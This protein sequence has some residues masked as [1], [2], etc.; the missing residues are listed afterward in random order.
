MKSATGWL[1]INKTA[2]LPICRFEVPCTER[3]PAA[4]SPRAVQ[5]LSRSIEWELTHGTPTN[6]ALQ[7]TTGQT[8]LSALTSTRLE[9]VTTDL[10]ASSSS[11]YAKILGACVFSLQSTFDALTLRKDCEHAEDTFFFQN[12]FCKPVRIL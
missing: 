10:F 2:E 7:L 6:C 8:E 12:A 9:L 3:A 11:K 4:G 1:L 5:T